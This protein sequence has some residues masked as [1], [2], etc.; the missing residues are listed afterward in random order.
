MTKKTT[1]GKIIYLSL[2]ALVVSY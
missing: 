1:V 2:N